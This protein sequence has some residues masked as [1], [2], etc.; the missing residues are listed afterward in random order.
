MTLKVVKKE[1]NE[2]RPVS[3]SSQTRARFATW[4]IHKTADGSIVVDKTSVQALRESQFYYWVDE[5]WRNGWI[6]DHLWPGGGY[7]N[8]RSIIGAGRLSL[9]PSP[10]FNVT[11][12]S[13]SLSYLEV[14]NSTNTPGWFST[15]GTKDGK[16]VLTKSRPPPKRPKKPFFY[17]PGSR[18]GP[19]PQKGPGVVLR[20]N[21]PSRKDGEGIS[22]Y[23]ARLATWASRKSKREAQLTLLAERRYKR[24]L[25]R[26]VE[27]VSKYNIALKRKQENYKKALLNY[28]KRLAK[29]RDIVAR[30]KELRYYKAKT[31]DELRADHPY[32]L[33]KMRFKGPALRMRGYGI[34]YPWVETSFGE[35]PG[36]PMGL[37]TETYF[38]HQKKFNRGEEYYSVSLMDEKTTDSEL[39]EYSERVL[40]HI[41]PLVNAAVTEHDEKLRRK[42]HQKLK[43]QTVH[44]GNIIA[45]RK[46]T[47][48]LIQ[49]TVK[50]IVGLIKLKK[51]IFKAVA[52]Y[53]K[54]PKQIAND[55]LAFKF[56]V[57]PLMNDIM[58][59][60]KYIDEFS[61]SPQCVVRTNTGRGYLPLEINVPG[62]RFKGHFKM[63]Y[64]VKF[65]VD[66]PAARTLSQFGLINPLEI[67]WEVTPWS[68]VVDWFYPVGDWISNKTADCGISFLTGTRAIQLIGSFDSNGSQLAG[69]VGSSD[70]GYSSDVFRA[71]LGEIKV[72]TVLT[73]VPDLPPIRL[74]NP[75]S[76]SHGVESVALLVQKLKIR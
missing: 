26:Y 46:Q 28:E 24:Q 76:W 75:L 59:F 61:D 58:S 19:E 6:I 15:Q 74:K 4:E 71:F 1:F 12:T 42:I 29:Y 40:A 44:I 72:R 49:S 43:N 22:S 68:F 65:R 56:G 54:S 41:L 73:D 60:A 31:A 39:G 55:V 8:Y 62:L 36:Y 16:L 57:E 10:Q 11:V 20:M 70:E 52:S 51:N 2:G 30:S 63:S 13:R 18:P 5:P 47:M 35:L 64:T 34:F 21:P 23:Q 67:L 9:T 53:A 45:E 3:Y 7:S 17:A 48:D 33:V 27:R 69:A 25:Q 50:R 38:M 14:K 66:N 37:E 32:S